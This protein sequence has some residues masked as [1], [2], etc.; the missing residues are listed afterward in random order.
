[1]QISRLKGSLFPPQDPQ[2][3]REET[4]EEKIKRIKKLIK[5]EKYITHERLNKTIERMLEEIERDD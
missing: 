4:R 1:V 2:K 3:S 5:D